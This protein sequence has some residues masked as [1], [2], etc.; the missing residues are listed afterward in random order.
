MKKDITDHNRIERKIKTD[1]V[2]K[3]TLRK[4][5]Q[6][7]LYQIQK[8]QKQIKTGSS[9]RLKNKFIKSIRRVLP[10]IKNLKSEV[11][12]MIEDLEKRIP[13]ELKYS[14]SE[15]SQLKDQYQKEYQQMV[16]AQQSLFKAQ[17]GKLSKDEKIDIAGTSINALEKN[18]AGKVI[19]PKEFLLAKITKK[20]NTET[21]DV[22]K[23]EKELTSEEKDK[24]LFQGEIK[25]MTMEKEILR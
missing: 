16:E 14:E 21:K 18:E 5:L 25:R 17:A 13:E 19:F 12:L 24:V 8:W 11:F 22:K 20:L 9:L 4:K 10:K 1:I 6:H 3:N 2:S 23:A 7:K 15:I